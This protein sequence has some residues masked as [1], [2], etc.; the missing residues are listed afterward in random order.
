MKLKM[1]LVFM[2]VL[3]QSILMLGSDV[4]EGMT[5]PLPPIFEPAALFDAQ[6]A[7]DFL[8]Q[9]IVVKTS[10]LRKVAMTIAEDWKRTIQ[11]EKDKD[12]EKNNTI[13][14]K[15]NA[16]QWIAAAYDIMIPYLKKHSDAQK[17]FASVY[18]PY[19]QTH[20]T[21]KTGISKLAFANKQYEN[22]L[23]SDVLKNVMFVLGM[24]VLGYSTVTI[25]GNE[26]PVGG[27][28]K[29]KNTIPEKS[30]KERIEIKKKYAEINAL[31]KK[32]LDQEKQVNAFNVLVDE[33]SGR[34]ALEDEYQKEIQTIMNQM[35]EEKARLDVLKAEVAKEIVEPEHHKKRSNWSIMTNEKAVQVLIEPSLDQNSSVVIQAARNLLDIDE[36]SSRSEIEQAF[37]EGMSEIA[38]IQNQEKQKK[39]TQAFQV[40]EEVLDRQIAKSDYVG[41]PIS[42]RPD[43]FR[44]F[45][46]GRA[47]KIARKLI[48]RGN[49]VNEIMKDPN[50]IRLHLSSQQIAYA[51][52]YV[53]SCMNTLQQGAMKNSVDPIV[54]MVEVLKNMNLA[55]QQARG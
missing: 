51:M 21:I 49:T 16:Q 8:Q 37:A 50:L 33:G 12:Q 48:E 26:H 30:A 9:K 41:Q 18:L 11:N 3:F 42:F 28:N 1:A 31:E 17:Q 40:A 35:T 14:T 19:L 36:S 34:L 29:K 13:D 20:R 55:L 2:S 43:E 6:L 45:I 38:Q 7:Q 10:L 44:K 23:Q 32:M 54:R 52:G 46:Q 15:Q 27:H 39:Y 4:S 53:Q 25:A 47:I 5:A 24:T 22:F